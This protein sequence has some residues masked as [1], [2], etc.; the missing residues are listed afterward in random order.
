[1]PRSTP[2][3]RRSRFS[4]AKVLRL[5]RLCLC[6]AY[7]G[8]SV[9][10][11]AVPAVLIVQLK[12]KDLP[13]APFAI[14]DAV[15]TELLPD[16]RVVPIVWGPTD[17]IYRVAVEEGKIRAGIEYPTLNEAFAAAGKLRVDYVLATD[18]RLGEGEIVSGA[19]LYKGGRLIWKD[20]NTD[21]GPAIAHLRDML[22]KKKITKEEYDR[23][24]IKAG[25]RTSAV[26]INSAFGV[27]DTI[28]S[29]ARTWVQIL[30]SGPFSTFAKQP[31]K[32]TPDPGAGQIAVD[33]GASPIKPLTDNKWMA[34][35]DA[36][37]KSDDIERALILIRDAV[38]AAPLDV[39]RR[40]YLIQTLMRA[41][42]YPVAAKEARRAADLMPDR[43][44][45]R[46]LAARAWI[47]AGKMEEA[48]TDL[49]EAVSH[50]PESVETR[51]LLA[52]VALAKGDFGS[53]IDHLNKAI[54]LTPSGDAY[55][56]RAVARAMSGDT[57]VAGADLKKAVDAGLSQEPRAAEDRYARVAE[58][59]DEGLALICGDI[60]T[61]H[62]RAQVQ[63]KEREVQTLFADLSKIVFGRAKFVSDLPAPVGHETSHNRWVLAHKLL[64]QCLIDLDSYLKTGN[65]DVLTES[66]INLGEALKQG[67]SAR[68]RFKD[69]Q[70]GLKKSDGKPG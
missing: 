68:Q 12:P 42:R 49:N 35:A 28:R 43:L 50:A 3:S 66:R 31:Q 33:P 30:N 57:D 62:Q 1:M 27:N 38:D 39:E 59:L 40:L 64:S 63:R 15:A 14:A 29:L 24:V 48:Q 61:L 52:D 10:A 19:Y 5:I 6:L 2:V 47:R 55:Y 46:G 45:F 51:Q 17:P 9:A 18:L 70:Q 37:I 54:T 65:E 23:S 13:P 56:M 4:G 22:K 53:A 11:V 26:Q 44:E 41:G 34:A 32:V 69:E 20:P 67:A 60:R 16:G 58:I 8:L 7:L 25:F 21:L 36:A